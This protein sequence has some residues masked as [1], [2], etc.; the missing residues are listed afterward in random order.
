MNKLPIISQRDIVCM[1]FPNNII[2][3]LD[4]QNEGMRYAMEIILNF[5]AF[6]HKIVL[7]IVTFY[8]SHQTY[9]AYQ[10]NQC[11]Y[12]WYLMFVIYAYKILWLASMLIIYCTIDQVQLNHLN[13]KM[14]HCWLTSIDYAINLNENEQ[15]IKKV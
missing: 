2:S 13:G 5:L 11:C 9:V 15:R 12:H 6:K 1:Y 14:H 8:Y 3:I 7:A 10:I 4:I